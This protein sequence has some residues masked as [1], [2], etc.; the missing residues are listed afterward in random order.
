MISFNNK[1][2]LMKYLPLVLCLAFSSGA[3]A[4]NFGSSVKNTINTGADS[5]DHGTRKVIKTGKD[6][7]Q[8]RQEAR[9]KK[10]KKA[11]KYY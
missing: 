2:R 8:Q 4:G 11:E 6:K 5:I 3:F 9:K 1:E 10:K 7:V